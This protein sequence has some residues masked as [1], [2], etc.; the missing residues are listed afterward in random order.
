[1]VSK[2]DIPKTRFSSKDIQYR[3]PSFVFILLGLV[4]YGIDSFV[5]NDCDS[6]T[7]TAQSFSFL[8]VSF[9]GSLAGLLITVGV[10]VFGLSLAKDIIS[11]WNS[12]KR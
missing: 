5:G 9:T 7:G 3:I 4:I 6:V 11:V 1:M 8:G 10:I 12:V 2:N